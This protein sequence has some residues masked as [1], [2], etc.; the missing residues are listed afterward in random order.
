M[1]PPLGTDQRESRFMDFGSVCLFV[2]LFFWKIKTSKWSQGPRLVPEL[3]RPGHRGVRSGTPLHGAD[4]QGA[5]GRRAGAGPAGPVAVAAAAPGHRRRRPAGPARAH[6]NR[7][8]LFR[9][10]QEP[11]ARHGQME[12]LHRTAA[13]LHRPRTQVKQKKTNEEKKATSPKRETRPANNVSAFRLYQ[14]VAV[15]INEFLTALIHQTEQHEAQ[16]LS[17]R[18]RL[19]QAPP[20]DVPQAPPQDAPQAPPQD[21]PQATVRVKTPER[22]SPPASSAKHSWECPI[23]G[24]VR[25]G[26][27][28]PNGSPFWGVTTPRQRRGV[29]IR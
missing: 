4:P 21:V 26:G 1:M 9:R 11:A 19:P 17:M 2:C 22:S 29:V 5:D 15:Y 3:H 8:N 12:R 28:D 25:V 10:R 20:Q 7:Q 6:R 27:H 16:D 18:T 14:S 24:K 23:C 13:R